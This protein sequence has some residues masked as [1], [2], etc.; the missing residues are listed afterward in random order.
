MGGNLPID[1]TREDFDL[2]M[3]LLEGNAEAL[4]KTDSCVWR[5]SN[6]DNIRLAGIIFI[7]NQYVGNYRNWAYAQQVKGWLISSYRSNFGLLAH[8]AKGRESFFR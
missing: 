4:A 7:S 1:L 8:L 3:M 2:E 5:D 6:I